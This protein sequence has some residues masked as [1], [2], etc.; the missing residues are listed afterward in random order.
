MF[1]DDSKWLA[2]QKTFKKLSNKAEW[3][4][5]SGTVFG[6]SHEYEVVYTSLFESFLRYYCSSGNFL[7]VVEPI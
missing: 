3:R 1:P 4:Y 6:T 7:V 5:I 2:N